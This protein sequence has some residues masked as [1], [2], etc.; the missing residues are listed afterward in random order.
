V[1]FDFLLI[2]VALLICWV[3]SE[4]V[5]LAVGCWL[6]AVGCWM[7]A[8]GCCAMILCAM[9]VGC[10]M[11]NAECVQRSFVSHPATD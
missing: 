8:V 7:L 11:M 1:V 6:L 9:C 10:W 3:T 5:L 2:V 4:L